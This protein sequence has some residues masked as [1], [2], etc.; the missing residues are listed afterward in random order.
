MWYLCNQG[1]FINVMAEETNEK[2][3]TDRD[4][5]GRFVKGRAKTGGKPKGYE[6]PAKKSLRKMA[7]DY[8]VSQWEKFQE[9]L[10]YCEPKDY[11]KNFI[12]LMKLNVPALQSVD[13]NAV[14]EK[15]ETIEGLLKER[16]IKKEKK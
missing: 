7:E 8:T 9:M 3:G 10:G 1:L 14:V 13:L 4:D 11:C 12:D 2:K 5:K 16:S 6:S 15:K